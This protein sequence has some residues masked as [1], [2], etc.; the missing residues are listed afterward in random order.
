MKLAI[1]HDF[2]LNYGGAER[3]LEALL[4]IFP[5]ADLHTTAHDNLFP[6]IKPTIAQKF[7]FI[8]KN[9]RLYF[10]IYP[11][12]I[13]NINLD[14]YDL[15]I[16]SSYAY[17][18]NI[19]AKGLNVCY[20]HSLPRFIYEYKENYSKNNPIINYAISKIKKWDLKNTKNVNYFIANSKKTQYLIKK[21][22]KKDSI[23][24][25]PFVDTKKFQIKEKKENYYL[26]ASRL[27]IPSKRVDVVI[28]AFNNLDKKLIIIGTGS[29]YKKLK[30]RSNENI[31]YKGM[32][33]EKDIISFYQNAKALIFPSDDAFGI[34]IIESQ[35]C[36]TPVIAYAKGGALE[37]VIEGKTGHF[38]HKQTP[39]ALIKAVK[40]FEKMKFN[41][42]EIRKNALKYDKEIFKKKIKKFV[43]EKYKE[44]SK[45]GIKRIKK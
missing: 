43:D 15:V 33:Q 18:K 11:F 27:N 26:L 24:I 10:F 21:I 1:F 39:E 7:P 41:P 20:L 28:E 44:F 32:L 38:F 36:G 8:K 13:N 35:S 19:K 4:E 31:F 6:D 2:L 45:N 17:C 42:K 14:K 12:I 22:Y 40:E 3:V 16:T 9:H 5:N 37:T 23:I 30:K 29:D 25:N 34:S